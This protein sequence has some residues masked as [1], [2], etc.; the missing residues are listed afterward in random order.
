MVGAPEGSTSF[1]FAEGTVRDG[2]QEFLTVQTPSAGGTTVTVT[3][4][5]ADDSG[6]PVTVP[7]LTFS[8]PAQSRATRD[9]SAY[10]SSQ[11]VPLPLDVSARV[12]TDGGTGI[13]VERPLYF[14]TGLAGGSS[15]GT[16]VVGAPEGSTSFFFAEGTVRPGFAEF[17]TLQNPATG[18]TN[19]TTARLAFQAS[20][21]SGR[22]VAL[23]PVNVTLPASSRRT[24][25]VNDI[26]G[27]QGVSDPV[28][29]SVHVTADKSIL[30]ERPVY[31]RAGLA[32]GVDGGSDAIGATRVAASWDF[33]EGTVRD[34]FQEFL[35][36]QNPGTA[37]TNVTVTFQ[38]SDDSGAPVGLPAMRF[39]LGPQSRATRDIKAYAASQGATTALDVSARVTTDDGVGI[40]VERPL[41]FRTGLAGG[42]SGGESVVGSPE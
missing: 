29:V 1:F 14:R 40:V 5:A 15:G 19:D 42:S 25:N 3:F 26:I 18:S 38:A 12:S 35:T 16:S 6:R 9:I 37:A 11:G 28:N 17:I 7:P 34:G 27:S 33:A 8:L 13:V 10:V 4:Q 41:Y 30:A 39:P 20:D 24:V 23:A 32:G 21:D 22:P 31:F 2:F 36:F